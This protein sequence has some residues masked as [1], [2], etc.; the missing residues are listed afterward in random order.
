VL[1]VAPQVSASPRREKV[2]GWPLASDL[3]AP[4]AGRELGDCSHFSC[5]PCVQREIERWRNG[6]Y[7]IAERGVSSIVERIEVTEKI[8]VN[9]AR[10][11]AIAPMMEWTV[12]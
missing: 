5:A 2:C 6:S 4:G 8:V 7:F 11:F 10:R 9:Q 3:N 1:D 12:I